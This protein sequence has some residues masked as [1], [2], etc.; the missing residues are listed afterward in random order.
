VLF[1][2]SGSYLQ[3]IYLLLPQQTRHEWN[4]HAEKAVPKFTLESILGAK[5]RLRDMV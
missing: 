1:L 5:Q 4:H 3:Q 2:E